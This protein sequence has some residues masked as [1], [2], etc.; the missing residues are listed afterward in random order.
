LPGA[1]ESR[2]IPAVVFQALLPRETAFFDLFEAH[3]A[4]TAEGVEVLRG[5]LDD[6]RDVASKAHRLKEIEREGD[7][8]KHRTLDALHRTFFTPLD[9]DEIQALALQQDKVLDLVQGTAEALH[10]YEI[11]APTPAL[12]EM[13][14][15]LGEAV[16]ALRRAV[17]L[18]RDLRRGPEILEICVEVHRLEN[19]ADAIHI[20]AAGRLFREERDPIAVMKWK[21]VYE[22]IE[23][24][25]DHAEVVANIL[26]AIVI[27]HA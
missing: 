7:A 19:E 15:V 12:K 8:V 11:P 5:L 18:L 26:H 23:E 3:A 27:E 24:A 21:E 13:A 22:T 1:G 6:Y 25:V 2:N 20:A 9:R 17:G 16:A 14:R 4:K 10:V